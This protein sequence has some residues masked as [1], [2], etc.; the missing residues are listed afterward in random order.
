MSCRSSPVADGDVAAPSPVPA[1][2]APLPP[3]APPA[4]APR[5]L[6]AAI[7]QAI[8][9]SIVAYY[10]KFVDEATKKTLKDIL[11]QYDRSLL[12]ADPRRCEPKKRVPAAAAARTRAGAGYECRRLVPTCSPS[13]LPV[14][15][16]RT[17]CACQVPEEARTTNAP[18]APPPGPPP[19]RPGPGLPIAIPALALTTAAILSGATSPLPP[20]RVSPNA[21]TA[22]SSTAAWLPG[23]LPL[24]P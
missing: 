6:A 22:R 11:L 2:T 18:P 20:A 5:L 14:Q 17:R 9:K 4:L 23:L 10:Q 12:V 19:A 8:A 1:P 3:D 24:E 15:V 7:R 13:S 21:A 16:R